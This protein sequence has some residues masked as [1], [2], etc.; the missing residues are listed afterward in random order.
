MLFRENADA[1]PEKRRH[2]ESQ[3]LPEIAAYETLQTVHGYVEQRAWQ[4]KRLF[5]HLLRIPGL[6][7]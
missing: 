3:I 2:L 1:S 5:V 4:Q 7:R 6:Y